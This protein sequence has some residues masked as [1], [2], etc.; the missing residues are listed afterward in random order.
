M[1]QVS[2]ILAPS[3]RKFILTRS[4]RMIIEPLAWLDS[5]SVLKSAVKR[6][7]EV[8]SL[9]LDVGID[10]HGRLHKPMA[11]QL[12]RML[13]PLHPLFIEG[14][15]SAA[16]LPEYGPDQPAPMQS[17]CYLRNLKKWRTWRA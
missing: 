9:G 8:N 11:K 13:E 3:K 12:A 1:R 2:Q 17:P 5:P 10:F 6:V 14:T 4:V 15:M 16:A 7:A